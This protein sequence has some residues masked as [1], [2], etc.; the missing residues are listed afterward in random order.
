[1]FNLTNPNRRARIIDPQAHGLGQQRLKCEE[2][3]Q[4]EM[5]IYKIDPSFYFC[6]NCANKVPREMV[7]RETRV[8]P[9]D[10]DNSRKEP[11]TFIYSVLRRRTPGRRGIIEDALRERGLQLTDFYEIQ[12]G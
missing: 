2:C 4:P 6:G 3:G 9:V 5:H 7:K 8:Q 10:G 12:S 1:M 11:K